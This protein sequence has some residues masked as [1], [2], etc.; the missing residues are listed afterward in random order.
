MGFYP[1]NRAARVDYSKM[2]E[3]ERIGFIK[4]KDREKCA[5]WNERHPGVSRAA[6]RKRRAESPWYQAVFGS[7]QRARDRKLDHNLTKEW[8]IATYTG[9]CF[10]TGI[11]FVVAAK[12]KAGR[13]G[14]R[15]YSP[16]IDR[17]NPLKGYTQDNCRWVL[18]AVNNFKG[19]MTDAEMLTVA[20]ALVDRLANKFLT[21]N[22]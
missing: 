13:S 16:S 21:S 2:T 18:H 15:T 10:L 19:E 20:K 6:L 12:E 11:P 7:G 8:A 5:R 14:G 4:Q 17:I 3:E 1:P 9:F 22:P